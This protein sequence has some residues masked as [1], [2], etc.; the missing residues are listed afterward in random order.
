LSGPF[1]GKR[2]EIGGMAAEVVMI[3]ELHRRMAHILPEA[4]RHLVSE[5]AIEGIKINKSIQL[6]SCDS[7]E[8]H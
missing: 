4:A 7:C 6:Q 5:G 8:T 1:Y 3:E 2:G